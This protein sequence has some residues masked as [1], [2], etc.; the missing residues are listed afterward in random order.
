MELVDLLRFLSTAEP[1]SPF[2][3]QEPPDAD[4]DVRPL[5][6]CVDVV[7]PVS[8]YAVQNPAFDCY[9]RRPLPLSL[10]SVSLFLSPHSFSQE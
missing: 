5:R 8:P 6:L 7:R 10:S 9:R 3:D 2:A 4:P 1:T